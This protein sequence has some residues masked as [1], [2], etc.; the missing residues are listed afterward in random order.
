M[1]VLT[2][3]DFEIKQRTP[4]I[5]LFDIETA[6]NLGYVWGKY[7]QNVIE[8]TSEW[9][10]LAWSAKWLGGKQITRGLIDY[11]GYEPHGECDKLLVV[12]LH[13]LIE[14]ADVIV[15]HNGDKFDIK[16][17]NTR[18]VENGLKPPEPF[19]TVDTCKVARRHFGFNSNKLDDLGRRLGVG[20]KAPTGGFDLWKGCMAGDKKAWNRMKRYNAQDVRLLEAVYLKLLP[21]I[22]NHP[23]VG[24]LSDTEN[25]CRNCG[26][27]HLQRR[28][29]L[30]TATGIKPRFQCQDCGTW[31]CGKHQK[32]TDVR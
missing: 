25:G 6:P 31:M 22:T 21:W 16:R 4:K 3:G 9:Y 29:R 32:K 26:G 23:H 10:M 15:A 12:E 19:R 14:Q 20:R 2:S 1:D 17:S 27:T 11:E 13:R 28:G 5:L 30:I 24:I 18:F 8:Y 7:E